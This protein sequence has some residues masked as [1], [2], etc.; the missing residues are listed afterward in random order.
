MKEKL[1]EIVETEVLGWPG[2]W[3]KR[4]ED[5]PGGIG[6]TG[7]RYGKP[8]IGHVHDDG[9]ADFSFPKEVRDELIE[10]GRAIPHP[11]FPNS[12]TV[13]SHRIRSAEDVPRA[14]ELFRMNYERI[15]SVVERKER[16]G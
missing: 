7:Y 3:K 6:V 13:A 16:T 2:V 12:R 9:H 15:K 1:L 11:A 5:A 10:A 8:Q 4:D 14:I